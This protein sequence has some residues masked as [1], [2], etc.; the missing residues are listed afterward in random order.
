MPLGPELLLARC[1]A[2]EGVGLCQPLPDESDRMSTWHSPA[3]SRSREDSDPET[4]SR[5]CL[6]SGRTPG[7]PG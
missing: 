4:R 5:R 3:Q 6:C 1:P 2:W 7:C